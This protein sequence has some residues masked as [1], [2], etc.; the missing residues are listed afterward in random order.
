MQTYN[1]YELPKGI[2]VVE[3]QKSEI[4]DEEKK[5]FNIKAYKDSKMDK[6]SVE[7]GVEEGFKIG[8]YEFVLKRADNSLVVKQN[9]RFS[10]LPFPE[11]LN[12]NGIDL[13]GYYN[14]QICMLGKNGG[15][16]FVMNGYDKP[17]IDTNIKY[18]SFK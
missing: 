9:G 18:T 4:P 8:K 7:F 5:Q 6:D 2:V 13:V 11:N 16:C 17:T 12:L 14:G 10:S 15:K 1:Q 3:A